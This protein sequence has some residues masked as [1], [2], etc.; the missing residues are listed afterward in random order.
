MK[1]ITI[2]LTILIL[3]A[4][5]TIN[6]KAYCKQ[7]E[8]TD[9]NILTTTEII[10][11]DDNNTAG[12]WDG[13]KEHPYQHINDGI[14]NSTEGDTVYVLSGIYYENIVV[15]KTIKLIGEKQN[16]TI[17]DGTY[18]EFII[19][20]ISDN[21]NIKNFTVKNSGG[22]KGDSAIK[23]DSENNTI[24]HCNIYRTSTGIQL[25]NTKNNKIT[26]CFFNTNGGGILLKNS[27]ENIIQ[28]CQFC[29]NSIG[30]D[31][32]DSEKN[33]I[34]DSYAHTN[35]IGIFLE[36]SSEIEI[37]DCAINDNNDNQGGVFLFGCNFINLT[38]CN[39]NHNGVGA[40]IGN[41]DNVS[42]DK[43]SI[44]FS[45][46]YAFRIKANSKDIFIKNSEIKHSFRYAI[47]VTSSQLKATNNN[48]Y[49][50]SI[51]GLY[52]EKSVCDVKNNWWGFFTGPAHTGLG[53]SDRIIKENARTFC[54][55]WKL[56]TLTEIGCNWETN[57]IF[58]SLNQPDDAHKAI[59]NQGEDTDSDGCTDFWE[60][61]WGYDPNFW[62]EHM[63]LDPDQDSLN[64]VEECFTDQWGSNPFYKDI[65][66][67]VDQIKTMGSS[68]NEPPKD[69]LNLMISAFKKH[70]INLHVDIGNLGGGEE[71]IYKSR[72]SYSDLKDLY[73]DYFLHNDLNNPRK[74]VF[75]YD[76]I[77]DYG[78]GAG[79]AFIG[80]DGLDSFQIA[81]EGLDEW[82]PKYSRG[83]LIV[84]GSMHELGHT[85][86]LLVDDF[87]GIDNGATAKFKN[88]EF[89][90]YMNYESCMS[91]Q[92]TWSIMDYSDG[93]HLG[94][95]FNDWGNLD[96]S[97]FKNTHF[98][99]P[100][101]TI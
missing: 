98:E 24:T 26:N 92:S 61:K 84:S 81:A 60:E 58:E 2:L 3:L 33:K 93:T 47:Y 41:S 49:Q 71:I 32:Q 94:R 73:W 6:Q 78:A 11:I 29:H 76:L 34:Y 54:I 69:Q 72:F 48:I 79:F 100:K 42:I 91:Y 15:D 8:T 7:T 90:L 38:N 68:T 23:I 43:C 22:H 44:L 18:G 46:H 62:N 21:V 40:H 35:G 45:T 64:N 25:N 96:F 10:Y 67:E 89:W 55:P 87:E 63:L 86:G 59:V 4:T 99:W 52:A 101:T 80:W 31:I 30:I 17:I 5:F 97:F 70:D 82:V 27:S 39:I 28:Y 83:R 50:N 56:K 57:G 51:S 65:F 1:K 9:N 37:L 66:L 95:D 53:K 88:K 12:P 77:C 13:T 36:K 19:N 85:L 14:L 16:N 75:H 74:G 20:I